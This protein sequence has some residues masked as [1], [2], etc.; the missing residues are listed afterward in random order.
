LP[1]SS[2]GF[3]RDL[4][5]LA[6][7]LFAQDGFDGGLPSGE[8]ESV[9]DF[10]LDGRKALQQKLADISEG[11]GVAAVDAMLREEGK[12]LAEGVID[13]AGGLEFAG[14]GPQLASEVFLSA[15]KLP[16]PGHVRGRKEFVLFAGMMDAE[17]TVA[18]PAGHAALASVG[19]GELAAAAVGLG[20][21][22]GL[23]SEWNPKSGKE[24]KKGRSVL[25]ANIGYV[26]ILVH[27][28]QWRLLLRYSNRLWK[29]RFESEKNAE[30]PQIVPKPIV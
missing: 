25:R 12:D 23:D 9:G 14:E 28:C 6:G 24:I 21:H 10:A 2:A 18:L 1:G 17:I 20:F 3:S 16:L 27:S 5:V 4:G 13:V 30:Y 7:S 11:H 29:K 22:I 15:A 26:S 19:K 8:A